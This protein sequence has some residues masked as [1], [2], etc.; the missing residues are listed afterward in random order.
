MAEPRTA[1]T[2]YPHYLRLE[3]TPDGILP[4]L[5]GLDWEDNE[6]ACQGT[7]L[8]PYILTADERVTRVLRS[9]LGAM[10]AWWKPLG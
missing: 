5:A 8:D 3:A 1:T 9:Y 7:R 2:T 6:G 4:Y 10:G